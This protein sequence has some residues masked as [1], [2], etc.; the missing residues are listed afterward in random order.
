MKRKIGYVF[1]LLIILVLTAL[2]Y[3]ASAAIRSNVWSIDILKGPLISCTGAGTPGGTDQKNCQSLCDLVSTVANVVYFGIGVVIW[4]VAPI[5]IAWSGILLM[6]SRGSTERASQARKMVT[7]VAIGLLIVLCA[8]LI[9]YTF[10]N[11][12]GIAGIGGFTNPTCTISS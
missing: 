10:V 5:M 6:L 3:A 7:S 2:P 4:I 9:V 1:P 11:V 8:Y 12:I